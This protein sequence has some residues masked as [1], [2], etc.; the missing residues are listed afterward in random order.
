M[1]LYSKNEYCEVWT[2]S[3]KAQMVLHSTLSLDSRSGL[4]K[5]L[6]QCAVR[7]GVVVGNAKVVATA[8]C[9]LSEAIH[10]EWKKRGWTIPM[11]PMDD[12]ED[13]PVGFERR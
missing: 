11:P 1:K 2:G 3:P 5:D 7:S 4:A 9:D 10:E 13:G 8:M 12:T 6:L